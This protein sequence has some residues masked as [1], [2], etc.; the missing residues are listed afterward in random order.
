MNAIKIRVDRETKGV[1]ESIAVL[2]IVALLLYSHDGRLIILA[3][4][5]FVFLLALPESEG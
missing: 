5:A 3:S 4:L 2:L 1:L